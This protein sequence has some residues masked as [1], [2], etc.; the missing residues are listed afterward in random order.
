MCVPKN[1]LKFEQSTLATAENDI[2][3]QVI[4]V[5]KHITERGFRGECNLTL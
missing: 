1:S 5:S 3:V 2:F 4:Q